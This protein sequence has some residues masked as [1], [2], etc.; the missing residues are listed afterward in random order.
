M[1]FEIISNLRAATREEKV[2]VEFRDGKRV[3]GAILF[4]ESKGV[5]K[6][7]NVEEEVSVDFRVE[8]L[9]AVRI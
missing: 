3:E 9:A 7:I 4:N 8:Q 6:V 1:N 5:G 2:S